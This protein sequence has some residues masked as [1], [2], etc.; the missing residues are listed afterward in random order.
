L[1]AETSSL[2]VFIRRMELLKLTLYKIE[3]HKRLG[4]LKWR[5]IIFLLRMLLLSLSALS[6]VFLVL[7]FIFYCLNFFY[8]TP[9]RQH[10]RYAMVTRRGRVWKR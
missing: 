7:F 8:F 3:I 10:E 4:A 6:F 2:R 1:Q 5:Q 9:Y